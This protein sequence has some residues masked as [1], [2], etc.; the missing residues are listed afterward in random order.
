M[1]LEA[2]DGGS[3]SLSSQI[4]VVVQVMDENDQV[5]AFL[6]GNYS[7]SIP[8]GQAVG[9]VLGRVETID[10]DTGVKINHMYVYLC[11]YVCVCV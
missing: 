2:R 1:L 5:P 6:S 8:E 10:T 11:C 4:L 7:Y 9:E 3:P